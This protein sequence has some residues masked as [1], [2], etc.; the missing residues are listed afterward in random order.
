MKKHWQVTSYDWQTAVFEA[1]QR[2]RSRSSA[3]RHQR[4][5]EAA[6]AATVAA[7]LCVAVAAVVLIAGWPWWAFVV[8]A[9]LIWIG[10]FAE[11]SK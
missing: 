4:A 2:T 1:Q 7:V 11:W 6:R 3:W 8:V 10:A 5:I 9:A